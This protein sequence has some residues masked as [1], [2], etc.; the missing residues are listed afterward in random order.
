MELL[1]YRELA[2][3]QRFDKIASVGM[4]EHV[5]RANMPAYFRQ[6]PPLCSS[7]AAW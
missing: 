5:G 6:D 4:F 3:S 2:E 1:D 7:P